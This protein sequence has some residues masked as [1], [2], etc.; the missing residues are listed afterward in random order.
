MVIITSLTV[1]GVIGV[2]INMLKKK[3]NSFVVF[4]FLNTME[5]TNKEWMVLV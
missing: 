3:P 1:F 5:E 2:E 4:N